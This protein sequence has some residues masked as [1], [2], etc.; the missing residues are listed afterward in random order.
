MLRG[1][2]LAMVITVVSYNPLHATDDRLLE[3]TLELANVAV[4]GLQGIQRKAEAD[5]DLQTFMIQNRVCI[6]AGWRRSSKTNRSAGVAALLPP[7]WKQRDI[8][9]VNVP[10]AALQGRGLSIE[11]GKGG[12]NLCILVLYVPP[13]PS[14]AVGVRTYLACCRQLSSWAQ[15]LLKKLPSR[16]HPI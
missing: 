5:L 16:F 3:I 11:R 10:P 8:R 15:G 14:S 9:Q 1:R 2:W 13:R 12:W 4:V 7:G 6:D